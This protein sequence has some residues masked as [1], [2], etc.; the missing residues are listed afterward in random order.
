VNGVIGITLFV[1]ALA[2]LLSRG[3]AG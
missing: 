3:L 1:F 2:D